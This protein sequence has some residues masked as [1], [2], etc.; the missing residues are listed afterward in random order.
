M[1]QNIIFFGGNDSNTRVVFNEL[2]KHFTFS[3]AI[4]ETERNKSLLLKK[5]MKKLGILK[6]LGQL[7]FKAS[8]VPWLRIISKKRILEI[9]EHYNFNDANISSDKI[10][11]VDTINNPLVLN[12][13]R[14]LQP[15]LIVVNGTRIISKEIID[16]VGCPLINMHVGITPKYRGVHGMY[17]ALAMSDKENAGVTIHRIDS[18]IDTGSVLRQARVDYTRKDNFVT[19]PILQLGE[20]VKI[21]KIVIDEF[22]NNRLLKQENQLPSQL[23]SHPTVWQYFYFYFTIG[24]K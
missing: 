3:L 14:D 9:F 13:V 10:Y 7:I 21:L 8:I 19:Y 2:S 23:W 17:W 12:R 1:K 20:G 18:G 11:E 4:I 24:V 6:V 15:A 5:R 16:G 22:F